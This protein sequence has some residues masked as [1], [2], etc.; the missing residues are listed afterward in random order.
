MNGE[1]QKNSKGL[2]RR[3]KSRKAG[4]GLRDLDVTPGAKALLILAY[5]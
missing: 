1:G 4:F 3:R 2:K 5:N